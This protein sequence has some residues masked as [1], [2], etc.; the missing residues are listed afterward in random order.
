MKFKLTLVQKEILLND[1]LKDEPNYLYL[2]KNG[3][4]EDNN[5]YVELKGDDSFAISQ[6]CLNKFHSTL[7]RNSEP[8][9]NGA[10][11]DDL[12]QIFVLGD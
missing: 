6:I 7:D 3:Y 8:K 12:G 4:L 2:I 10:I 5:Y 9:G 1:V 11:Y